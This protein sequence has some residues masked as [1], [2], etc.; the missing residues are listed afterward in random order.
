MVTMEAPTTMMMGVNVT[1]LTVLPKYIP[2]YWDTP[3]VIILSIFLA[4]ITIASIIGNGMVIIVVIYFKGMHT[5]TNMFIVNLAVAD[6]G[7]AILC[8][9]FSLL[10]VVNG[11]WVFGKAMCD[12]NAF[13]IALFLIASIHGLMYISI[14][15]Y[16]SIVKPLAKLITQRR[17]VL[18]IVL[19]WAVSFA[20]AAGGVLGWTEN[21]YKPATAQCGPK[22]PENNIEKSHACFLLTI[23][24]LIP[25]I[26]LFYN[27]SVIFW[28]IRKYS[29]RLKQHSNYD[30]ARILN[31]QK[32]I[33]QTL[34]IVCI[35]FFICWTPY[36]VFAGLGTVVGFDNIPRWPNVLV[37]WCGY[38]SSAMNPIIYAFRTKSYRRA[39]IKLCCCFVEGGFGSGKI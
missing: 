4:I 36:F 12:V 34:F 32:E 35:A 26:V 8:M 13:F 19:S 14:H 25:L 23:G 33:T 5:K 3:A 30:D 29:Q 28:T 20:G 24:Y 27:Y 21:E 31:Q 10:T 11:N 38:A 37:Y 2:P 17:A 22:F 39:F 6:F 18:M 1:S 15:K 9:P 7:V 16:F